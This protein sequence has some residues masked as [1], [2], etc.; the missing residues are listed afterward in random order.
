[1]NK[2]W[3]KPKRYGYGFYPISWEGYLS[4]LFFLGLIIISAYTNKLFTPILGIKDTISF[5]FDILIISLLFI[6]FSKNKTKG[7]LRWRWG[8]TTLNN[9]QNTNEKKDNNNA[10]I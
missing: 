5:L 8:N 9:N 1:M 4:I 3:F 7:V 2:Y 6:L 10:K